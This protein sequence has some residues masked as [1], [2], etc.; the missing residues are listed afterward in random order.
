MVLSLW[1][2]ILLHSCEDWTFH[3]AYYSIKSLFDKIY[4]YNTNVIFSTASKYRALNVY[5]ITVCQGTFNFKESYMLFSVSQGPS[6]PYKF[7]E[8][9]NEQSC[10]QFSGLRSWG[11]MHTWIPFSNLFTFLYNYLVIFLFPI[12]GLSSG[13]VTIAIPLVTVAMDLWLLLFP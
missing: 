10:T 4:I 6:V 2:F 13:P 12:H 8:K 1:K 7:L 5:T 11:R 9:R 3:Y